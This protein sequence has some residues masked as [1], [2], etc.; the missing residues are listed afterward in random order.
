VPRTRR[1]LTTLGTIGILALAGGEAPAWN[2]VRRAAAEVARAETELAELS[3]HPR[4]AAAEGEITLARTWIEEARAA[5]AARKNRLAVVLAER[6][7]R[8]LALVRA[9]LALAEEEAEVR[10]IQDESRAL[11]EEMAALRGRLDRMALRRK[12]TAATWAYPPL[13]P[14]E[15]AP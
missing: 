10:K 1:L 3:E 11:R 8:Q 5:L 6:L 14:S 2:D 15:A 7:P 4:A 13:E 9:V 12:G